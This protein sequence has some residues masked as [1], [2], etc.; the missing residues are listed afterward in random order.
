[1]QKN[2]T[3][4]QKSKCS[5]SKENTN[6]GDRQISNDAS[7]IDNNVARDFHEK[8]NITEG[9]TNFNLATTHTYSLFPRRLWP[10]LATGSGHQPPIPTTPS[11]HQPPTHLHHHATI[12]I[13]ATNCHTPPSPTD[14]ITTSPMSPSPSLVASITAQPP[15]SPRHSRLC[16]HLRKGSW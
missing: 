13:I 15:P 4:I 2:D 16:Q 5:S 12:N 10:S 6:A 3:M 14:T 9:F 8:E 7:E 11:S 1:M